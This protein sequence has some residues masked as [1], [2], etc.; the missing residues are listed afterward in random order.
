V[1]DGNPDTGFGEIEFNRNM[2]L[3]S[4]ILKDGLLEG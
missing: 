3:I 4:S 2:T 1:Q